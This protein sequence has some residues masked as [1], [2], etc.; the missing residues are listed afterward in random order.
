MERMTRER[1]RRLYGLKPLGNCAAEVKS[2]EDWSTPRTCWRRATTIVDGRE[3]CT[4]HADIARRE[5]AAS[6]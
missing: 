2:F 6:K 3:L 5:Q 4:Q 1:I